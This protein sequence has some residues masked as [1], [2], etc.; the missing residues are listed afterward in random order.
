MKRTRQSYIVTAWYGARR[1]EEL[2]MALSWKDAVRQGK[3]NNQ[4]ADRI[5]ARLVVAGAA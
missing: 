1:V 3:K 4:G 2:V 5:D